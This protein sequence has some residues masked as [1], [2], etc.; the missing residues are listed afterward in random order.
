MQDV[1]VYNKSLELIGIVDAYKSL[2]WANRYQSIGDCELYLPA[3][4]EALNLL[5]KD[6]YLARPD[7]DMVCQI[8]KIELDTSTEDGNYLIVTG[9]DVKRWLD[10]RIIWSTQTVDGNAE[11]F[12]R[13]LVNGAICNSALYARQI[14]KPNGQK[15]LFLGTAAGFT[16]VTTE[17]VTYKN[18][19]EKVREYCLKFGWGYR[20]VFSDGAFYFQLYKGTNRT[21][22]VKF[23]ESYENLATS[24]YVEDETNMGNVALVAGQGEGSERSR[25]VSGYAESVDRYEIYVDAKDIS[26]NITWGELTSI[27]PTTDQGGQGYIAGTAE[28]GYTYKMNYVNIQIVDSDQLTNLKATYPDGQEV[29][30]DGNLYYQIYNEVIADL[31]S[32]SLSDSDSVVL[33]DVIYSVYLLTRGY[34]KLAEYGAVTSFEGTVEPNTTFIYNQDYFLGD[35]VTIQNEF[36]ITVQAR[37]TEVVEVNDDTGYSVEPKFEYIAQEV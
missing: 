23:S 12:I 22:T 33:R 4:N 5:Q 31:P 8:K 29:T 27:Y 10:Q 2:I 37:I 13:Q 30:I 25:N 18:L 14:V 17:Q 35:K 26:K 9:L 20:V 19:G 6:Y 3:T 28:T 36:G 24:S 16:E 21:A 1:Y 32:N 34:E 7:S 15:M 11:Q